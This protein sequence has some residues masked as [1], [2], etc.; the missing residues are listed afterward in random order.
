MNLTRINSIKLLVKLIPINMKKLNLELFNP[1]ERESVLNE[2]LKLLYEGGLIVSPSDTVYGLLV[3]AENEKAVKKLIDFKRRPP[4][5]AISVFV[6]DFG[7]MDRYAEFGS[8]R[9]ILSKLLPGPFTVILPSKKKTSTLLESEIG[10]LG[11]RIPDHDFIIELVKKFGRAVTATSAN[12]SGLSP[13]YSADTLIKQLSAEK[14]KLIDLI[15]DSGILP[16]NKPS[17]VID[18]TE[19][20]IKIVRHGDILFKDTS[21]FISNSPKQTKKIA[22]YIFKKNSN[23]LNDKPLIFIIEG[24]L[25]V[26]KTVFVKGIGELLGIK[27]I[28][29]PTF[30]V[31]YEYSVPN[32]PAGGIFN[33]KLI[34]IDLYNIK[35]PQEFK[36]LGLDKYLEAKNILCFEWG[37]KAGEII[38]RLKKKCEIVY[39]KMSYVNEKQRKIT[40]KN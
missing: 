21:T 19:P 38:N 17:T 25:G 20:K 12:L 33:N 6:S 26:G 24:E 40:I 5:K 30:V 10:T 39:V 2:C 28:V 18:L 13:H 15:I 37:E 16:R 32:H 36:Y 9:Q 22:Q 11:L 3:D 14:K 23:E 29:S 4:G 27:N 35:E 8:K 34:H 7:M 1:K 31:Y